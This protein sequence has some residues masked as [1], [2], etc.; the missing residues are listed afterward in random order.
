MLSLLSRKIFFSVTW[1]CVLPISCVITGCSTESYVVLINNN[2]GSIGK[3]LVSSNNRT[4]LLERNRE[5]ALIGGVT[6]KTFIVSEEKI[7]K[8]FGEALAASPKTPRIFLLYFEPNGS[9]L[10]KES[11]ENIPHILK[12]IASRDVPDI[13]IVGYTDTVGTEEG[14]QE[15]GLIRANFVAQL[16]MS[17]K[18]ETEK[19]SIDSYGKK[20]LLIQTPDNREEPLNRRVE[21]TVR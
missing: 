6:D 17:A 13:S 1:G 19:V 4:T 8:E 18:V 9:K 5:G 11:E 2:D 12:E 7:A 14:N 16:L 3:V 21:I 15:I 20:N 10:T